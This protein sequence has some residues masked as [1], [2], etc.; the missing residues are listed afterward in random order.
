[1]GVIKNLL[2]PLAKRYKRLDPRIQNRIAIAVSLAE[3]GRRQV[4]NE[5]LPV[6][7]SSL[8]SSIPP[9]KKKLVTT[10]LLVGLVSCLRLPPPDELS[11][12][13]DI[14]GEGLRQMVGMLILAESDDTRQVLAN[15]SYSANPDEARIQTLLAV[16]RLIQSNDDNLV[17]Q[18]NTQELVGIWDGF[19][20]D[21]ISGAMAGY[22]RV[23][24]PAVVERIARTLADLTPRG[25][26]LV[27]E[28][29]TRSTSSSGNP[30]YGASR[31]P[32]VDEDVEFERLMLHL[33]KV[34]R[35]NA[36]IP[37]PEY[38]RENEF[39]DGS[40][41]TSIVPLAYGLILLKHS[42]HFLPFLGSQGHDEFRA[43]VENKM[44]KARVDGTTWMLMRMP[45]LP[46]EPQLQFQPDL[47][48]IRRKVQQELGEAFDA[49]SEGGA[50]RQQITA[51]QNLMQVFINAAPFS[52]G[53]KAKKR[54]LKA[55]SVF[56]DKYLRPDFRLN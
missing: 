44:V 45:K 9:L 38:E 4:E 33:Q 27:D 52:K 22:Q 26:T 43:M 29:I 16:A 10:E 6:V 32:D 21:Y 23:P 35:R 25:K 17:N 51:Q 5:L 40:I 11:A 31:R 19:V 55:M 39:F 42:A 46:F 12:M 36:K 53:D 13:W 14:E 54:L 18:L 47:V 49:V 48:S 30:K 28:L 15:T 41:Y 37:S 3:M 8:P 50:P 7:L 2:F 24:H 56:S 20:A 34:F 1:M